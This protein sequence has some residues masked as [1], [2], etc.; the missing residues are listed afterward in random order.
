MRKTKIVCTLGPKTDEEGVLERMAEAGMDVCRLNFSHGTFEEQ[1]RRTDSVKALREK[2]KKPIGI[3]FDT[4]GP[5]IRIGRFKNGSA[6]LRRGERFTL[7]AYDTEG[8]N[9]FV[10][11]SYPVQN[12]VKK[13]GRIL[14]DD[15][16]IELEAEEIQGRDTIC[17]VVSGG[18]LKSSKSI[19]L[20]GTEL[21]MPYITPRDK[22]DLE[23]AVRE[24]ADFV[25]ASF[26]RGADDVR[27][28]RQVLEDAGGGDIEV[29]S[30]IENMRGVKNIDEIIDLSDG[31][32]V[33][34]G[35]M[36]VEIPI[37]E[38]PEIQKRIIKK[39]LKR[40]KKCVTA[41]QMLDSMI[42]NPRP[43]RAE[44]T[45]I[46]NAILDGT[47]AIMLSG[48]TAC[49][50]YAV[51]SVKMMDSVARRIEPLVPTV[52]AEKGTVPEIVAGTAAL[53]AVNLSA[54]VILTVTH[55]GFTA[56]VVS[57]YRPPCPI[58]AVT[59]DVKKYY[60]MSLTWGVKPFLAEK[61]SDMSRRFDKAIRLA[62]DEGFVKQGGTIVLTGGDK[63][64][65]TNI[66]KIVRG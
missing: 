14:L 65:M 66:L 45:D 19:N 32:M 63:K 6:F 7:C 2:L 57:K 17:R 20:P 59:T 25:A 30:K 36:G 43:T 24:G 62:R 64:G 21:D 13:G 40:G 50:E 51:E 26:V 49:G 15:G 27:A 29:I 4:K 16:L 8:G 52:S 48:E 5:E 23:F 12:V 18:E 56:N 22:M 37:E 35:D 53:A 42:K 46:A 1:K 28:L 55:S 38:L 33:A 3:M 54:D 31:I 47:G 60:A 11:V 61:E 41:T 10:S 34:R 9:D 39:C 44:V 58:A